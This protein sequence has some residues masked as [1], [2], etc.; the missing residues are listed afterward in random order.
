MFMKNF[1]LVNFFARLNELDRRNNLVP[2]EGKPGLAWPS[3]SARLPPPTLSGPL[4]LQWAE[5]QRLYTAA[6][7]GSLPPFSFGLGQPQSMAAELLQ[8][9]RLEQLGKQNWLAS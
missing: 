6:A 7:A 2:D 5:L 4:D 8:R 1:I 9:E 3:P